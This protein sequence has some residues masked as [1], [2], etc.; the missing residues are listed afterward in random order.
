MN[1]IKIELNKVELKFGKIPPLPYTDNYFDKIFAVYVIYFWDD[2]LAVLKEIYRVLKEDGKLILYL[3]TKERLKKHPYT[4]TGIFHSY[5]EEQL[6]ELYKKA[7][8]KEIEIKY[9]NN[10]GMGVIGR[11]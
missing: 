8:F 6:R 5:T 9:L 11:K 10:K 1:K 7:G 4:Q 2:P 3:S